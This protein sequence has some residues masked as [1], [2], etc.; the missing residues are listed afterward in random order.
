M[1]ES[2]GENSTNTENTSTGVGVTS[3]NEVNHIPAATEPEIPE[4]SGRSKRKRVLRQLADALNGCLCGLV[5]DGSSVGG[6]L[7]CKQA[8]CETQW[9]SILYRGCWSIF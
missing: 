1:T 6:V 5:L 2:S 3:S 9:V 7:K 4:E 8:S